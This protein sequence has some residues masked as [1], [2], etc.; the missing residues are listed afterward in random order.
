M[1]AFATARTWTVASALIAACAAAH[2]QQYPVT[3]SQRSAAQ[4]VAQQGVPV[5]EL[6][7]DAPDSYTVKRGDTLWDISKLFLRSPW[8]WPELWGM[9]LDEIRNPHLIYPGQ[10]LTLEKSGGRARLRVGQGTGNTIKL[11]PRV[12]AGDVDNGPIAS[13]ALHL[14]EPFLNDAV[15]LGSNELESAPRIVAGREGRVLLGRG[16]TAYVRGEIAPV[17]DW[18]VF[19]AARP[20]R[21][22]DSGEVLEIG[23]AHV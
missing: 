6:A 12:R 14:I 15:V 23:R 16:D 21:D 1:T 19:R 3:P 17:R 5:G 9:N 11:S 7:P 18:R 8:R 10:I 2:A 20:L 4:Q 13:I 22:P